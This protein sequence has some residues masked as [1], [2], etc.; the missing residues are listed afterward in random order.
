MNEEIIKKLREPFPFEA[1]E[2]KIQVTNGDKTKGLAVFYLD[3]RAIQERLDEVV[4]PFNWRNEYHAWQDKSQICGL[5]IFNAE[6]GE[7]VTKYDGAENSDIE[8]IKGGLTDAFKRSAVLWSLG[9]Y[10]YSMDGVWCDVDQRGKGYYIKDGQQAKLKAEYEKAIARIF[11]ATANHESPTSNQS[12]VSSSSQPTQTSAANATTS[13]QPEINNQPS[14][15]PMD[16]YTIK[17]VKPSGKN[18]SFI[19]LVDN[20]GEIFNAYIKS[21]DKSIATGSR[22]RGVRMEKRTGSFGNYNLITA[23]KAA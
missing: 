9:R 5:S 21:G 15:T 14:A 23:Y 13:T 6:R 12:P 1:V 22:L 20:A 11:G 17:S 10:L 18:S 2:A 7:W 19:E 4:G 16:D 8:S 3:A